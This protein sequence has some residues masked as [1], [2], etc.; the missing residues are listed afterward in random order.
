MCVPKLI[1]LVSEHLLYLFSFFDLD[2]DIYKVGA[3]MQCALY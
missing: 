3:Y 2:M 1:G